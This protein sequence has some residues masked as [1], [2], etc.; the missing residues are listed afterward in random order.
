[1]KK[2]Q[3]NKALKRM[4]KQANQ[5]AAEHDGQWD[6][7]LQRLADECNETGDKIRRR[8]LSVN[9]LCYCLGAVHRECD[10]VDEEGLRR[11]DK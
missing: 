1:M 2:T 5:K 7:T 10:V 9:V 4:L 8:Q 3:W 11:G 6:A